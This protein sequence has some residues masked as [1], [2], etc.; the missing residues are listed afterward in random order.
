MSLEELPHELQVHVLKFMLVKMATEAGELK[1]RLMINEDNFHYA[2][3]E[4]AALKIQVKWTKKK[5]RREKM[6]SG[7]LDSWM[8]RA[9]EESLRWELKY[10]QERA[11]SS[12]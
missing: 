12:A 9:Q 2:A 4:N 3:M 5:L 1:R 11:R 8:R 6:W 7:R 10:I